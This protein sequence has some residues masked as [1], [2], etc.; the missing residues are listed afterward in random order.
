MQNPRPRLS[1]PLANLGLS[2]PQSST[3]GAGVV[4]N[5]F[6]IVHAPMIAAA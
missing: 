5:G 6:E 3:D 2:Q 1:D 4:P